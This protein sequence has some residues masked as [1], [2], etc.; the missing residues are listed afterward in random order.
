MLARHDP[1]T[2]LPNRRV[3]SAQLE[4]AIARARHHGSTY[5]VLV[6]DLDRFKPVNDLYGHAGGDTVLCEIARRL[7]E[8]VRKGDTVA[9]LGGDEFAIVVEAD[10]HAAVDS[11]RLFAK[12]VLDAVRTPILVGGASVEVGA[13][14]G[15]ASCP[16]DGSEAEHLLRA[17][18]IAMYRAK[19]EGRGTFRFFEQSM[20]RELRERAALEADFRAAVVRGDI[21]PFYQPLVDMHDNRIYGFEIL[22]RWIHPTRGPI[23]PE[24]FVPLAEQLGLISQLTMAILRRACHDARQWPQDIT[25][26]LNISPVQLTDQL[27]P[28]QL[29]P[30]PTDEGFAPS[31]LE[32]EITE[33][34]LVKDAQAAKS[35]LDN[36]R[37]FGIKVSLDDFGTGYSSLHHLRELK[38]DKVKIDRSFVQSMQQ[39]EESA[40]I[41]DAILSLSKGLGLSTL[42]EGIENATLQRV[43][44]ERGCEYG[45]GHYF[46]RAT[47]AQETLA[48]LREREAAVARAAPTKTVG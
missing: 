30:I 1:L 38:F 35:I 16:L 8:V 37:R 45:Q 41:V 44:A 13:S 43:L 28:F 47:T 25:L 46:G 10:V 6:L 12:R 11:A 5:L 40:K 36:F 2:G 33:T 14:I 27:L 39:N 48:L 22:A 7:Q 19:H 23:S 42:A 9:R 4:T 3:L 18:D 32:V 31:R 29:L 26:A 24:T 34:A 15:I 21:R 17:A 20:D